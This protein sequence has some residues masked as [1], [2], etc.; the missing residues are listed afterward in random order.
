M[1]HPVLMQILCED[2]TT[3]DDWA[4]SITRWG[5]DA[6]QADFI[7]VR[8]SGG[9]DIGWV[10]LNCLLSQDHVPFI[11]MLAILPDYWGM[12]YGTSALGKIKAILASRG[13]T[14][15][16]LWTDKCNERSQRCY[17]RNGFKTIREE[18]R[19]VGSARRVMRDRIL[20][21]C[22]SPHDCARHRNRGSGSG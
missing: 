6:D 7:I 14:C 1:N 5:A 22:S 13:F 19:V 3:V 9:L 16:R 21:E 15:L 18:R 12:G 2:S 11:R 20:M 10:G 8:E 4:D 17:L